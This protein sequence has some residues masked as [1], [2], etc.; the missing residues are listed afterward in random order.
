MYFLEE[1]LPELLDLLLGEEGDG[2]GLTP[3]QVRSAA[4]VDGGG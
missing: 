2:A 4:W 3:G 1:T